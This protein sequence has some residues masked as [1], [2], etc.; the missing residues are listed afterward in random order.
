MAREDVSFKSEGLTIKGHFY[1]P[2]SVEPPY[3]CVVM[4]GGWCYVKELIQPDYA[5]FFADAGFAALSFDI[6]I[7]AKARASPANTSIP[8]RKSTISST[9][10]P[11]R[12]CAMMSTPIG[13]AFGAFPTPEPMCFPS[14]PMI[15]GCAVSYRSCPCSAATIMCCVRIRMSAIGSS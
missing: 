15:G 8:G 3:P 13:S 10:S 6:A 14:P 4:G 12:H 5:Q 11:M 7:W 1:A 2:D 9:P